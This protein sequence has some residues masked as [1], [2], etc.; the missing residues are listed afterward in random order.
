MISEFFGVPVGNV[1]KGRELKKQE[2]FSRIKIKAKFTFDKSS[3]K[4]NH[5][6]PKIPVI[7]PSGSNKKTIGTAMRL[8]KGD[9][10]YTL[11]K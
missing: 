4:G 7:M 5:I 6:V 9:I 11:L 10:K 3:A 2:D 1:E 8:V